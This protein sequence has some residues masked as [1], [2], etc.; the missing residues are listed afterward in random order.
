MVAAQRRPFGGGHLRTCAATPDMLATAV[1]IALLGAA[2]NDPINPPTGGHWDPVLPL[3]GSGLCLEM[4]PAWAAARGAD[5]CDAACW[6]CRATVVVRSLMTRRQDRATGL[7]GR[8]A[9][10]WIEAN[11]IETIADFAAK[12]G[13]LQAP[14]LAGVRDDID[15]MLTRGFNASDMGSCHTPAC[16]SYDDQGWWALAWLKAWELTGEQRFL[17]RSV[18]IFEYLVKESWDEE[19]CGGGCWWNSK[20]RYKNSITNQLFFTLAARLQQHAEVLVGL[21][22]VRSEQYLLDWA[23]KSWARLSTGSGAVTMNKAI[24]LYSD[25]L[26][27]DGLCRSNGDPGDPFDGD[28]GAIWSY[29]QGVVMT[30]L[31]ALGSL[32]TNA[33]LLAYADTLFG[34]V[35][36]H[37][38]SLEQEGTSGGSTDGSAAHVLVERSCNGSKVENPGTGCDVNQV[39]FKG[40]FM[41]HLGYLRRAEY[42]LSAAQKQRYLRFA[43]ENADW[44]W[45]HA[46]S[47]IIAFG[48]GGGT[49]AAAAEATAERS[50]W[51]GGEWRGPFASGGQHWYN[52]HTT[53]LQ[54][55]VSALALFASLAGTN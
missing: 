19:V 31:A 27:K 34:N 36:K 44:V 3:N 2:Q 15:L 25:G 29:N 54:A 38:T 55:Q 51:L 22:A 28:V 42:G 10:P 14:E 45:W 40:A 11:A 5:E 26:T 8:S 7:F 33:S 35:V 9:V 39:M 13:G 16:G 20:Q 47:E 21:G 4:H 23:L 30:G 43:N 41:R 49:S 37:M 50:E 24:G 32:S 52:E 18:A 12:M 6:G 1:A 46:R 17:L 48:R 53:M